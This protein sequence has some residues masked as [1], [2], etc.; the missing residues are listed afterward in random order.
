MANYFKEEAKKEF[1]GLMSEMLSNPPPELM[2]QLAMACN[3]PG[4]AMAGAHLGTQD[5]DHMWKNLRSKSIRGFG[6]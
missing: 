5:Y 1:K 6:N 3:T 2:Q 4:V